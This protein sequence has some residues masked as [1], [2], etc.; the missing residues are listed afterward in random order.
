[1]AQEPSYQVGYE[2]GKNKAFVEMAWW[3]PSGH[4][5]G[6]GCIPCLTGAVIVRRLAEVWIT[7]AIAVA[8][9]GRLNG[10]RAADLQER[11]SGSEEVAK[12]LEA[13]I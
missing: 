9:D 7:E 5:V 2:D 3:W 11:I 8:I 6:C 12:L 13:G 4:G 10:K 1:M